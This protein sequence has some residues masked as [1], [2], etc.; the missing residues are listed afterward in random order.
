MKA[1]KTFSLIAILAIASI[2]S[3]CN[4]SPKTPIT[5]PPV[6]PP[7]VTPPP[8]TPPETPPDTPPE[9][10]KTTAEKRLGHRSFDI[11]GT[12]DSFSFDETGL[13]VGEPVPGGTWSIASKDEYSITYV[14]TKEDA[15]IG[16]ADITLDTDNFRHIT[17]KSIF[18]GTETSRECY[19][20]TIS[21]PTWLQGVTIGNE[22]GKIEFSQYG[23]PLGMTSD[24]NILVELLTDDTFSIIGEKDGA[25]S[26][27]MFTRTMKDGIVEFRLDITA[28]ADGETI[29]SSEVMHLVKNPE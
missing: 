14:F 2:L 24:V 26:R 6:T 25:F 4:P 22:D 3:G 23:F 28:T 5:P 8:V 15:E 11:L 13:P 29:K 21:G 27:Y 12:F 20:S 18:G 1:G 9:E 10:E 19:L 17:V 7:P 16:R